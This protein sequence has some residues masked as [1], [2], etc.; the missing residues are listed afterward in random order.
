[1]DAYVGLL[2]IDMAVGPYWPQIAAL[3]KR[4]AL[5]AHWPF[6]EAQVL[7]R[8]RLCRLCVVAALDERARVSMAALCAV[9]TDKKDGARFLTALLMA[10]RA[11]QR[12]R[13]AGIACAKQMGC[14]A[15]RIF[16]RLRGVEVLLR[17]GGFRHM[18]G[19]GSYARFEM[20][21]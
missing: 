7:E 2:P 9:E 20:R 19:S 1:M 8:I 21:V 5:A 16:T 10:G 14:K 13:E 4:A 11:P 12:L 18:G 3:L 6:D 15:I 17:R